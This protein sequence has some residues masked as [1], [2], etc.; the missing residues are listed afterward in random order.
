MY[1]HVRDAIKKTESRPPRS[2]SLPNRVFRGVVC[3]NHEEKSQARVGHT[4][5]GMGS[6]L[7][8]SRRPTGSAKQANSPGDNGY[9]Y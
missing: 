5:F 2:N 8:F 1:R 6:A 4:R 3:S 9:E 7:V